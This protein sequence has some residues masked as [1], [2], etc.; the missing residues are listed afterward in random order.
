MTHHACRQFWYLRESPAKARD[1]P[2]SCGG[3]EREVMNTSAPHGQRIG[4][5]GSTPQ[6]SMS[7]TLSSQVSDS[8]RSKHA[9]DPSALHVMYSLDCRLE[10]L[11]I[12]FPSVFSFPV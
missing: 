4:E 2:L 12:I 11:E 1:R 3:I 5:S 9:V 6:G 8:V 7:G 10:E